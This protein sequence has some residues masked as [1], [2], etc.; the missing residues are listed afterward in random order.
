MRGGM[1]QVLEEL[2]KGRRHIS[3]YGR[4]YRSMGLCKEG[5]NVQEGIFVIQKVVLRL[6]FPVGVS[7]LFGIMGLLMWRRRRW[8]FFL[9]AAGVVW[10][11]VFSFP[12]TGLE[13]IGSIEAKAGPY[14]N[15]QQ[16]LKKGVKFIVVLSGGFRD[17]NIS[18]PDRLGCSVLRLMEGVRLW[19]SVPGARLVVTGGMTPGLSPDMSLAQALKDMA[20]GLGVPREAI[21]MEDK[22]WT[23]RDQSMFI[24]PIVGK[25]PFALVT[26]AYH[27]PRS[28]LLFRLAGLDPIPAPC[29][30]LAKK[31]YYDYETLVPQADGLLL[32]QIATKEYLATWWARLRAWISRS[33]SPGSR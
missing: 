27:L 29:D 1:G 28:L 18:V 4:C 5:N 17:G 21:L 16:L 33:A 25:E 20:V 31:Y 9:M 14:A 15:P 32:S 11:L 19:R 12:V 23:T 22:S 3:N 7:L 24:K 30:F 10:L 8:S 13:L 2:T 26:S 6:L